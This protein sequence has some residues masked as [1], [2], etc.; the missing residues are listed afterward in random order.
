[1]A[2]C[3]TTAVPYTL[4]QTPPV[5]EVDAKLQKPCYD[6]ENTVDLVVEDATLQA[7]FRQ[8]APLGNQR[9]SQLESFYN[10][11]NAALVT[12]RTDAISTLHSANLSE[13]QLQHELVCVHTYYERQQRHLVVRV[14]KSLQLLKC[15]L[16]TELALPSGGVKKNK[17]RLLNNNAVAVMTEWYQQHQENPYPS[18]EEKQQMADTGNISLSQVKAWFANKRNRTLNT[19]PKRQKVR[20]HQQLTSICQQLIGGGGGMGVP[21]T[22]GVPADQSMAKTKNYNLIMQDLSSIVKDRNVHSGMSGTLSQHAGI[23]KTARIWSMIKT[24]LHKMLSK[25][26]WMYFY[27]C[28]FTPTMW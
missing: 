17:S 18:D 14:S 10:T 1:M 26:F 5:S 13:Q 15:L 21:G 6:K 24:R 16:P 3:S 22:A 12:Q 8:L 7:E 25:Y 28:D 4:V 9:V 20:A 2:E 19:K 11:Q 27:W 23:L